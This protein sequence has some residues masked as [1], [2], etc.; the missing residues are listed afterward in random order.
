[1][2][3]ILIKSKLGPWLARNPRNPIGLNL[4]RGPLDHELLC[5]KLLLFVSCDELIDLC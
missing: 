1:M 4:C 5:A 3:P 2:L